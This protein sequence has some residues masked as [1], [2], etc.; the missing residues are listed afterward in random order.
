MEN[1]F[2]WVNVFVV[3]IFTFLTL[4]FIVDSFIEN[5]I[6]NVMQ[7]SYIERKNEYNHFI[8]RQ[9]IINDKVRTIIDYSPCSETF[10][11]DDGTRITANTYFLNLHYKYV[12]VDSTKMIKYEK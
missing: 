12:G 7:K 5:T 8:G 11:L 10:I 2:N 3:A 1:K 4:H 6:Y 9:Y